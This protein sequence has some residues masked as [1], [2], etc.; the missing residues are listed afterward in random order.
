MNINSS[1]VILC[2]AEATTQPMPVSVA[3]RT[4][5]GTRIPTVVHADTMRSQRVVLLL[6]M[7]APNSCNAAVGATEQR[8]YTARQR[9]CAAAPAPA[10]APAPA[11]VSLPSPPCPASTEVLVLESGVGNISTPMRRQVSA[12]SRASSGCCRSS[13]VPTAARTPASNAAPSPPPSPPAACAQC[14]PA[15]AWMALGTIKAKVRPVQRTPRH[16]QWPHLS[17]PRSCPCSNPATAA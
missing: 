6:Q 11:L 17:M 14:T 5:P 10:P 2:V 1:C 12:T 13:N 4:L 7:Q 9:H 15:Y 16:A 3:P 8:W